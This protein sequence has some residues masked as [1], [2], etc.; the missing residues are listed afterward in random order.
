M[1]SGPVT[2]QRDARRAWS[3]IVF[4]IKLR[5][6]IGPIFQRETA[7]LP[8]RGRHFVNR[9]VFAMM[10][11]AIVCT[12]W[13]L[14]AGIQPVQ[15]AGDLARFGKGRK[16]TCTAFLGTGEKGHAQRFCIV[17]GTRILLLASSGG[18]LEKIE[19]DSVSAPH[20]CPSGTTRAQ[21]RISPPS[22]L[23]H[24]NSIPDC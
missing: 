13:L 20:F 24:K 16:R 5:A 12:T 7:T 18:S 2:A 14:L 11:F 3:L 8:R 19:N 21:H 10:L 17:L 15:N 23:F 22:R 4:P 9:V 1:A 6:M